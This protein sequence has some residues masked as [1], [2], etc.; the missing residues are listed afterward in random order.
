MLE[1]HDG[2]MVSFKAK[3][4]KLLTA[5]G[6]VIEDTHITLRFLTDDASMLDEEERKKIVSAVRSVSTLVNSNDPSSGAVDSYNLSGGTYQV[7]GDGPYYFA[8]ELFRDDGD[9]NFLFEYEERLGTALDSIGYQSKFPEFR[10]HV[11]LAK[12]ETMDHINDLE[13]EPGDPVR[14]YH[15]SIEIFGPRLNFGNHVISFKYL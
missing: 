2:A 12:F 15:S 6:N 10:A 5:S 4:A 14:D 9:N 1:D 7:F 8:I 11:S 3:T 13:V